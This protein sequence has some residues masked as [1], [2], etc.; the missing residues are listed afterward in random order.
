MDFQVN[1]GYIL[2]NN[3]MSNNIYE[4]ILQVKVMCYD[5]YANKLP[6]IFI[7]LLLKTCIRVFGGV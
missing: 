7:L 4:F 5:I 2:N 1:N 6:H 3:V